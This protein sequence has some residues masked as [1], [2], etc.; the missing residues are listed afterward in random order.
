MKTRIGFILPVCLALL[1]VAAPAAAADLQQVLTNMD[2][3]AEGF[4]GLKADVE[5][6]SYT[7]LV[8]DRSVESGAIV[9]RRPAKGDA[10][11]HITFTQPA[12]KH[13]VMHGADVQIYQP[14]INLVQQYDLTK[15]KDK[16]EQALLMGFG[17]SGE[18]LAERHDIKVLGEET[19]AGVD[20][21]KLELI[22]KSEDARAS[23]PKL[24]MWISKQTWQPVQQKLYQGGGDYRLYTYSNIELNPPLKNG[25]F[26]LKLP[27]KVKVVK[28]S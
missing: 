2:R 16:L 25:D 11:L 26:E 15:S 8:N 21:V 23:M 6:V 1:F 18:Y 24:E 4:E 14:K 17:V 20:A 9:V 3:A 28:P 22:P 19:V 12:E 7:A 10:E 13:V 5:W 27:K